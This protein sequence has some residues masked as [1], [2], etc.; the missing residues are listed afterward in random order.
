M[1]FTVICF[2]ISATK[3]RNNGILD[4]LENPG[5]GFTPCSECI[6]FVATNGNLGY[7]GNLGGVA[8]ADAICQA[9]GNAY[10]KGVY[11]ALLVDGSVRRACENGSCSTAKNWVLQANRAYKRPDGTAIG[12]TDASRVFGNLAAAIAPSGT[13]ASAWTGLMPTAWTVSSSTCSGWT[14]SET[15]S[16]G[17]YGQ[18]SVTGNS[19]FAYGGNVCSAALG[20]YCVQQ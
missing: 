13:I 14:T 20:V 16:S 19:A 9:E 5:G 4:T 11:R 17:D 7:N 2:G 15:G 18:I 10:G 3:C 8:G 12:T 6:I 1:L